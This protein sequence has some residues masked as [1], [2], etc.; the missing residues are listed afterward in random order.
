MTKG[1]RKNFQNYLRILSFDLYIDLNRALPQAPNRIV[2]NPGKNENFV[3]VFAFK[4]TSER[5]Y[6]DEVR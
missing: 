4:F 5:D 3:L 1:F 6:K 2:L